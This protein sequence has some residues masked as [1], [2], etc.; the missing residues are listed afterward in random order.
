MGMFEL[1]GGQSLRRVSDRDA[2]ASIF[3]A[4]DD[5]AS[6]PSSSMVVGTLQ[7]LGIT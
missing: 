1:K 5:S 2:L 4:E 7:W 6:S 3:A